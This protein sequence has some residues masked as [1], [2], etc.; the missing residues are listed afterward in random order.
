[1]LLIQTT[2][3]VQDW[4]GQW[5]NGTCEDRESEAKLWT[6][7]EAELKLAL[8]VGP[9]RAIRIEHEVRSELKKKYSG[10][11]EPGNEEWVECNYFE[12]EQLIKEWAEMLRQQR[13]G[14]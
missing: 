13:G 4:S 6:N 10:K 9:G 5:D 11:Y 12:A 8:Y 3:L 1:L 7:G 2:K 14:L